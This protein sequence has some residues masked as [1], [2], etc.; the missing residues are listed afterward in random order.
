ML[1]ENAPDR[2]T[3]EELARQYLPLAR[4]MARKHGPAAGLDPDEAESA[5]V[6]GMFEAVRRHDPARGVP[7][8]ARVARLARQRLLDAGRTL[9]GRS[10][11]RR[12]LSLDASMAD[13]AKSVG[14]THGALLA[15]PASSP[16]LDTRDFFAA[17]QAAL[18]RRE[19]RL[20]TARYLDG[21]IWREA[22]AA[23][24]YGP[25]NGTWAWSRAVRLLRLHGVHR[26]TG[27]EGGGAP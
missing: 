8:G 24:G 25:S 11:E 12:R 26:L 20:V 9:H 13:G 14:A 2:K 22:V 21:L 1:T 17:V 15:A 27:A 16:L 3:E 6:L 10:W 7:L 4:R 19:G 18:P 23:A 5:A